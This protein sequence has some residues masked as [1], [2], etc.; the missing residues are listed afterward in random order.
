MHGVR[1]VTDPCHETGK[2][3]CVSKEGE[4][5]DADPTEDADRPIAT[6]AATTD[7][8][9][10]PQARQCVDVDCRKRSSVREV[11]LRSWRVAGT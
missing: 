7:P 10:A 8:A 5:A 11:A 4:G 3:D 9:L 1:G 6:G 2:K